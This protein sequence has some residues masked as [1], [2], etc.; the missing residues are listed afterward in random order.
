M[1][2]P[3]A[4]GCRNHMRK[5]RNPVFGKATVTAMTA[6]C[7]VV[8]FLSCT[9]YAGTSW[10][11]DDAGFAKSAHA[12]LGCASCHEGIDPA[13]HPAMDGV[14]KE[15][16]SAYRLET[17]LSCHPD[18]E[19][20]KA[21][22]LHAGKPIPKGADMANCVSCHNPHLVGSTKADRE[23][24]ELSEESRA[25]LSCHAKSA[26]EEKTRPVLCI[27]CHDTGS[28]ATHKSV[29]CLSCHVG[30]AAYPHSM[31]KVNCLSCHV[32]H[33]E[34]EIHDAHTR[35][36]CASCH[37][38]GVSPVASRGV[39]GFAVTDSELVHKFDLPAGTASCARC[40]TEAVPA[41]G[42]TIAAD[43]ILPPKGALCA[44]CH[45]ATLTLPDTPSRIGFGVL[46]AG[47]AGLLILWFS[48]AGLGGR[49]SQST[50]AASIHAPAGHAG[51][52]PRGARLFASV[53]CDIFLQARLWRESKVRWLIHALIFFPFVIRACLGLAASLGAW[54]APKSAWPWDLLAKDWPAT[55]LVNDVCGVLLLVG[56]ALAIAR[57]CLE[58]PAH[59]GIANMPKSDL[60][61]LILLFVLT[62]S[63]F[64][65]E[66]ARIA[67]DTLA[68]GATDTGLA[69]AGAIFAELFL[70]LGADGIAGIYG[71]LWYIHAIATAA[72]VACIPFTRLRHIFTAPLVIIVQALRRH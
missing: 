52:G 59:S 35:V 28:I 3:Y 66:G 40:H 72:T 36:E 65:L 68:L 50:E 6:L 4:T 48:S 39:V 55:A 53:L 12:D 46:V 7:L 49:R 26:V 45:A 56:L 38:A 41:G 58:K 31:E 19:E 14:F 21:E 42:K 51:H 44:A 20:E 13:E 30:A 70:P 1:V 32:R 23:A 8:L 33:T 62:V 22:G 18:V 17:C 54:L 47:F 27:S 71:T 5:Q 43:S 34:S 64:V 16:S 57:H 25:C 61:V 37:S 63:G 9:A 2:S 67:L 24:A 11:M 10:I 15:Q 29:S 60:F 69:F